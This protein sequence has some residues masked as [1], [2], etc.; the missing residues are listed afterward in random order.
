MSVTTKLWARVG[1]QMFMISAVIGYA[2]KHKMDYFIPDKTIAPHIWPTYFPQFP[3]VP[4]HLEIM[5]EYNEPAHEYTEI[6]FHPSICIEGY[7]QSEKY[8][9]HCR[10]D[11]L[12][13]FQIPYK[14]IEFVSIHVRRGDY[15]QYRDKH[16]PVT[17]EYIK[18]AVLMFIEKGY[19][20]FVVC[21]DDIK[22]CRLMFKGLEVYG[23]VFT[24]STTGDPILDLA[25]MASCEHNICSNSSLSWWAYYLNQNPDKIGVMPE[26]WFGPGNSHL[27][28]KDL[29]P[30]GII[31]L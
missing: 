20:S 23:A 4:K 26:I 28:T 25:L 15:L 6:P 17:Y 3:K 1:N 2:V 16:P 8:F 27:S 31:K 18:E 29:Y 14:K 12:S 5:F 30:E 11:I 13:A 10:P 19:N 9:S 24:Y 22:W 7:F 21:S